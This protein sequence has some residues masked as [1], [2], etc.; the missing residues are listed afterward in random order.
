[1]MPLAISLKMRNVY[2]CSF[3]R[4]CSV[5]LCVCCYFPLQGDSS[6]PQG[7][8]ACSTRPHALQAPSAARHALPV[9]GQSSVVHVSLPPSWQF[10]N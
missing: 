2:F 3:L 5:C 10:R 4:P 6:V 9:F 7:G 8:A 1:M